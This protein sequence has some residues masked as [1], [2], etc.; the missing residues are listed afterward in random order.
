MSVA[1]ECSAA[2]PSCREEHTMS[3][4]YSAI[5]HFFQST[6][7]I[8]LAFILIA[9]YYLASYGFEVFRDVMKNSEFE[10]SRREI[11]AYV[12]EKEITPEQGVA[13]LSIYRMPSEAEKSE[14]TKDD[15]GKKLAG[16]VAWG[17]I[18][19][20]DAAKIIAQRHH[21]NEERWHELVELVEADMPVD[22]AIA[23]TK[24]RSGPA[25]AVA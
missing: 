18:E 1:A 25:P 2:D 10:K 3:D 9:G 4:F 20:S 8:R 12:A 7:F 17:S 24:A 21:M 5:L 13:L 11:A 23:L 22:E 15:A 6:G 14:A 16:L 19:Q